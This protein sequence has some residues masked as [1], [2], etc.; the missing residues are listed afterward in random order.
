VDSKQGKD[1]HG[2]IKIFVNTIEKEVPGPTITYEALVKLAFP[3]SPSGE[4]LRF[5]VIYRDG[6]PEN[7]EGSL[8]PGQSVKIVKGMIFDVTPTTQS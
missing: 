2:E 3:N 6:P 7:R 4:D 8:N 5:D 1:Q